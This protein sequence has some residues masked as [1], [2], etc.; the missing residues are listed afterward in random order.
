[1]TGSNTH[2]TTIR[3]PSVEDLIRL[4]FTA[5]AGGGGEGKEGRVRREER[6][7]G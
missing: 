5:A 4:G 1:M 3:V 2:T 6:K 7:E